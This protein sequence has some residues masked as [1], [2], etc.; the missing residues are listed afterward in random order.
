MS[1]CAMRKPIRLFVFFEGLAFIMAS[2]IHFGVLMHGYEHR[3]A[4]RAEGVIGIA[5][6]I[7][8]VLTWI[9]PGWTR[10]I[11]I[12]VQA[13]ALLGTSVGIY[14][15]AIGIGPR[16]IPD[17]TFHIAIVIALISGLAV[18]A[19]AQKRVASNRPRP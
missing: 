12:A 11:G 10:A 19:R 14:T 7:G 15:I 3:W 9:L 13:F 5:L 8:C 18:T 4:G 6:L 17:I 1:D 16:T 2:L